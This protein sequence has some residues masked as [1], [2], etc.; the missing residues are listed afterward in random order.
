M[1]AKISATER[2]RLILEVKRLREEGM[3]LEVIARTL[4][5]ASSTASR[6]SRHVDPDPAPAPVPVLPELPR[7]RGRWVLDP[8]RR[9]QVWR[10]VA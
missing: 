8:R 1:G 6:Y 7:P 4:G 2:A 9:I 10:A 5:I 3:T